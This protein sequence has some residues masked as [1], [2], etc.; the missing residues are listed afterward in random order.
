MQELASDKF[1]VTSLR[2]STACGVSD[3]LRL[4]LV[5]NDFVAS[6]FVQKKIQ[7]LSDGSPWRPIIDVLDMARAFDWAINR[8]IK[9]SGN[10]LIVNIGQN[11]NNVQIKDLAYMVKDHFADTKVEINSNAEPDKRSYKVDFSLFN[12]LAPEKYLPQESISS[13]I[14]RIKKSLEEMNFSDLKF[15]ESELMRLVKIKN[16]RNENKLNEKLEWIN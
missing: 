7:I 4:D 14:Q 11:R 13:T 15:R 8:N 5:L 1:K 6:A 9:D 3:R 12:S 2:F 10:Y 16:L